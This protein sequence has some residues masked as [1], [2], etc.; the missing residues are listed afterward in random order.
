MLVINKL[1][2]AGGIKAV[3]IRVPN[4]VVKTIGGE[5]IVYR[6]V[7]D[8]NERLQDVSVRCRALSPKL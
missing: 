3:I 2:R 4:V 5:E 1:T 7:E 6:R 8:G